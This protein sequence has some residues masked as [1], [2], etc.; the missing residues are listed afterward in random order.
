MRSPHFRKL[1]GREPDDIYYYRAAGGGLLGYVC[2]IVVGEKKSFRPITAWRNLNGD[3][4][5]RV[6]DFAEPK[7]LFGLYDLAKRPDA[8]VLVVEGE[9]TADA[10]EELFP[11]YVVISWPGGAKAVKRADWRPLQGRNATIWPDADEPGRDAATKVAE[12]L[13]AIGAASITIDQLPADLPEGWDLADKIPA[14]IK[15]ELV[16]SEAKPHREKL[17]DYLLSARDLARMNLPPREMIIAPFL[18][19]NSINL[20]YAPRG[21][22][23]TWV[24]LTMAKAVAQGEDWIGFQVPKRRRV[25]YIDGEMPLADLKQRLEAIGAVEAIASTFWRRK[26]CSKTFGL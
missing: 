17:V 21:I 20:V 2:R 12:C 16:L 5:W 25:L 3:P 4:V 19:V 14:S 26:F 22:G 8:P 15:P 24:A 23:K 11:E 9:K 1:C 10:A 13:G 6:S 7:P 18:P